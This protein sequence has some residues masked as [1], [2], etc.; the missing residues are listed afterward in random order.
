MKTKFLVIIYLIIRCEYV[1]SVLDSLCIKIGI[2]Y[3]ILFDFI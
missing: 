2:R 1:G 3:L